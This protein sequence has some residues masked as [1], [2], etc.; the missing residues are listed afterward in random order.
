[1]NLVDSTTLIDKITFDALAKLT[2]DGH[3]LFYVPRNFHIH[4]I[5]QPMPYPYAPRLAT[6]FLPKLFEQQ[7]GKNAFPLKCKYL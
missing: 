1:M 3:I 5:R 4:V 6:N 2:V 7:L